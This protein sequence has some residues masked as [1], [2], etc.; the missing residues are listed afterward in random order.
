[1]ILRDHDREC[2]HGYKTAHTIPTSLPEWHKGDPVEC[3]GGE[4]VETLGGMVTAHGNNRVVAHG[5]QGP[6]VYITVHEE[7]PIGGFVE[8]IVL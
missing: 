8:V 1:M 6:W 2:K 5:V 3:Y 7:I 4:P